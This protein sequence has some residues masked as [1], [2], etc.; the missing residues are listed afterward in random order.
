VK[1]KI[2]SPYYTPLP[3]Y[4]CHERW[5]YIKFLDEDN[6]IKEGWLSPEDQCDNPYSTCG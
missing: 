1:F 2:I 3:I 4:N 6:K 5:L